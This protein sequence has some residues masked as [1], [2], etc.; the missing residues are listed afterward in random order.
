VS[1]SAS[2]HRD[3]RSIF[4][5]IDAD[6]GAVA[7][8]IA[9]GDPAL[10][11]RAAGVSAWS[12]AEQ[13]DHLIK[14]NQSVFSHLLTRTPASG[15]RISLVGRVVLLSGSFPRG[16]AESP[17]KLRGQPATAEELSAAL[18]KS[19]GTFR[20]LASEP[21]PLLASAPV[22]PHKMFGAM[23]AI[24]AL[25]F[26]PIHTRHHLKIVSEIRAAARKPR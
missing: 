17:R 6:F 18:E 19:R 4:D 9:L 14:V 15:P 5:R 12:V 10:G 8:V 3:L 26:V 22:L 25:R 20:R 21:D 16:K 13:V 24:Q 11:V 2:A 23:T 1:P 7:S